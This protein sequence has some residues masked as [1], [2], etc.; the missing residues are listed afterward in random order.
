MTSTNK[1]TPRNPRKSKLSNSFT[2]AQYEEF[3][4]THN[5]EKIACLIRERFTER[6]TLPLHSRHRHGFNIMAICCLMIETLESFHQG[7]KDTNG[8]IVHNGKNISKSECS[9]HLFF[10]NNAHFESFIGWEK[11]FY[12]GIRCGILHQAETTNGW[13]IIRKG[14]LFNPATKNINASKFLDRIEQTLHQYCSSLMELDWDCDEWVNARIKLQQICE[15]CLMRN[16][17]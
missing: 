7:W 9:F 6:F 15:N 13:H 3:I 14:L 10:Q 16:H 5:R 2:V 8:R 12:K 17:N 1:T 11:D 4:N